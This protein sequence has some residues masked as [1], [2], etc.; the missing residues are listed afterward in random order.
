[1][2]TI[3]LGDSRRELGLFFTELS[4]HAGATILGC[5]AS[6]SEAVAYVRS[7]RDVEFALLDIDL[8]EADRV[9]ALLRE[10]REDVVLVFVTEDD[11]KAVE[12]LRQKV[13][14]VVFKPVRQSDVLDVLERV[15]LLQARQ[16]K[17]YRATLFGSFDFRIDDNSVS[18]RSAKARELMALL[19]CLRGKPVSIHE[20][21]DALWENNCLADVRSVGYRKAIKSL[22]D[23]LADYGAEELLVRTRG[24]CRLR[25]EEI[26]CDYIAYLRGDPKKKAAFQGVFLPEY[27]W[28]EPYIYQLLELKQ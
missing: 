12:A 2:K 1:M 19:L 23:T 28:A 10:Q 24:Y 20:I 5:F 6:A 21:V 13:D 15:R 8:P 9:A 27:A 11:A 18:F 4:E 26:D 14:Y 16:Q 17:R 25:V 3:L 22:A 7:H